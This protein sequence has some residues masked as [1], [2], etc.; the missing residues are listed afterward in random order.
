MGCRYR[1]FED[2]GATYIVFAQNPK[3]KI[4]HVVFLTK[5]MINCPYS[6][7]WVTRLSLENANDVSRP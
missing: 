7:L 5:Q 6:R 4:F 3:F 2:N 1:G